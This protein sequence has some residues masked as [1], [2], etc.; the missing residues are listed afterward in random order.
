M[1]FP[2][3]NKLLTQINMKESMYLSQRDA[4]YLILNECSSLQ[5][6]FQQTGKNPAFLLCICYYYCRLR[7]VSMTKKLNTDRTYKECDSYQRL[8]VKVSQSHCFNPSNKFRTFYVFFSMKKS[9]LCYQSLSCCLCLH[10]TLYR[11]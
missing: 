2:R 11:Q 5:S 3:E 7:V 8:N 1:Y 4:I 10:W 6:G 9:K